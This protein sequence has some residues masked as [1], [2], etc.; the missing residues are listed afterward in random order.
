MRAATT[1]SPS[2]HLAR[3]LSR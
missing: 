1:E 2:A 3:S